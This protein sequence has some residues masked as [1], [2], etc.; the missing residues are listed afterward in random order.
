VNE[1]RVGGRKERE[2]VGGRSL[3]RVDI[4]MPNPNV[5]GINKMKKG[6][7]VITF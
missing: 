1:I 5:K 6:G 2:R 4:Q 7:K 3:I